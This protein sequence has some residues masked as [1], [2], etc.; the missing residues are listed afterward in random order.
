MKNVL[1]ILSLVEST[2]SVITVNLT[3]LFE[4]IS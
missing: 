2:V 4:I 3:N 1:L